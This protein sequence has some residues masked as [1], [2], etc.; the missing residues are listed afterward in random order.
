M[1]VIADT[2]DGEEALRLLQTEAADL[3]VMDLVLSNLDGLEL[4][5]QASELECRPVVLVLSSFIRGG[6]VNQAAALGADYFM[7]KPCRSASVIERIRQL[8]W[9]PELARDVGVVGRQ[10]LETQVTSIIHEIG[11]PAHIKG[12]QYLREAILIAVDNMDVIN[13]VTKVLYPEVAK[14]FGTTAS[15]VERAIRHAIEVAWDRGDLE[16]LQK[17][18][19]YTVSNAKGKPT[20]SEF[21]AMIAD[22]ISLEQ[23]GLE[24]GA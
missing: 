12:Y 15:R 23:K 14:R 4:L 17:Y 18:F 16:T 9:D 3:L 22:R 24:R 10:G 20:N 8:C 19:G 1:E 13:A 6:M 21:I 7:T 11:V 2:G 5:E